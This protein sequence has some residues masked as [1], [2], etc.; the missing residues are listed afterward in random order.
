MGAAWIK[1]A[2]AQRG[3]LETLSR[4]RLG[5]DPSLCVEV[6]GAGGRNGHVCLFAHGLGQVIEPLVPAKV[7]TS[8]PGPAADRLLNLI[9]SAMPVAT[10]ARRIHD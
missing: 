9:A 7:A 1:R 5:A 2:V 10:V 4:N 6:V 8:L 3:R